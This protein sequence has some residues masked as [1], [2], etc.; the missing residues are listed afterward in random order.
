M[1]KALDLREQH[2][3][4]PQYFTEKQKISRFGSFPLESPRDVPFYGII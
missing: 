1:G 4:L 3:I 2:G